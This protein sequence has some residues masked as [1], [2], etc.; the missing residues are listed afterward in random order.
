MMSFG[1]KGASIGMKRGLV[2]SSGWK[3]STQSYVPLSVAPKRAARIAALQALWR[4]GSKQKTGGTTGTDS[5]PAQA[6][7]GPPAVEEQADW[8]KPAII[9]GSVAALL[10]AAYYLGKKRK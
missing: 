2:R 1:G 8:V 6:E 4:P 9:A 3:A 5:T 10:G 7:T